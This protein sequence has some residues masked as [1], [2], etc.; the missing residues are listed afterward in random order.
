M[1]IENKQPIAFAVY[2]A[3][4]DNLLKKDQ[5]Y[6]R[7]GFEGWPLLGLETP[8]GQITYHVPE[9]YKVLFENDVKKGGPEWDQHT[10]KDVL[11]RLENTATLWGMSK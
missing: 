1:G 6:W 3:G 2:L 9:K 8:D 10:S 5:A 4:G 11:V 7:E